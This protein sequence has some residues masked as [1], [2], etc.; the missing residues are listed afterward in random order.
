M[1]KYYVFGRLKVPS[2]VPIVVRPDVALPTHVV[3][4][5]LAEYDEWGEAKRDADQLNLAAPRAFFYAPLCGY[6]LRV[7]HPYWLSWT[8]EYLPA[9]G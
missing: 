5:P 9:D 8:G 2:A 7:G 4:T 3:H 1:A 6:D